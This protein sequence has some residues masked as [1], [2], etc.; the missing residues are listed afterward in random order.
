M[1][2]EVVD[3]PGGGGGGFF[4]ASAVAAVAAVI[5]MSAPTAAGNVRRANGYFTVR[6]P[7]YRVAPAGKAHVSRVTILLDGDTDAKTGGFRKS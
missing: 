7:R 5:S 2:V 6:L 3:G 1:N 4:A